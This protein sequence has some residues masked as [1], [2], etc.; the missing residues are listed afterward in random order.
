MSLAD[1]C[2]GDHLVWEKAGAP[3]SKS[4]ASVVNILLLSNQLNTSN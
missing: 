3:W 2:Q 4:I 1:V